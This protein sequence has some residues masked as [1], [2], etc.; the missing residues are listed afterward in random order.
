M[1][2]VLPNTT[3]SILRGETVDEYGDPIDSNVSVNAEVPISIIENSR[4]VF[5]AA[6]GRLTVVKEFIGRIRPGFDVR[7]GDRLRDDNSGQ[8]YLVEGI[9]NPMLGTG[10]SDQRISLRRIDN[11]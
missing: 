11:S 7:E 4:R 9:S 10:M 3:V 2:A 8:I 6:E 5:L 1:S